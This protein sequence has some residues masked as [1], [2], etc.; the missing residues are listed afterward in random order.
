MEV[1]WARAGGGALAHD[2]RFRAVHAAD[3]PIRDRGIADF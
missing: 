1:A 3:A 2:A